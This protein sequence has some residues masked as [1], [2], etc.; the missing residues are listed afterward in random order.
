MKPVKFRMEAVLSSR[1]QTQLV[2]SY[3]FMIAVLTF[4]F[5]VSFYNLSRETIMDMAETDVY[6]MVR[7]NNEIID[8]K[9]SRVREMIVAFME[10]PDFHALY[11][12][13]DPGDRLDI[14]ISDLRITE[15]LSK[16]FSQSRDIYSVQL[17]ADFFTFGQN[18]TSNSEHGKN[19]I[20]RG[21]FQGSALHEA[22]YGGEGRI[23]WVPTYDVTE[24]FGIDVL[25]HVEIDYKYLWS[26]VRAIDISPGEAAPSPG[27][28]EKHPVLIVNFKEHLFTD[29]F[30]GSLPTKGSFYVV[31]DETG[32]VI[33][34][35][36]ASL[37]ARRVD[38]PELDRLT[39]AASGVAM[40][41]ID[42][43]KRIVSFDRSEIT[44]WYTIAVVPPNELLGPII[45]DFIRNMLITVGILTLFFIGLS[46]YFSN[47]ITQP[48]R[49]MIRAISMTGEGKFRI[50]FK[51]QGSYEFRVLMHRFNEMNDKIQRLIEENYI[52]KLREKEA[53]IKS[54][55]LQ[56]DPHFMH[57]T[58]NL[59]NL[60]ALEKGEDE[61]SELIT[62][63]SY[64]MKYIVKKDNLVTYEEDLTYLKSYVVIMTKRFEGKFT[65]EFDSDPLLLPTKVPKFFLQPIIENALIHGFEG[66]DRQGRISVSAWFDGNER[67]FVVR[68]N[69]KGMTAEQIGYLAGPGGGSV[70][71]SNVYRRIQ[72]IYGEHYGVSV[73]SVPGEGTTVTVRLPMDAAEEAAA[74]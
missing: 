34:H 37:L 36:D 25:R 54:L 4:L 74:G 52:I 53:E 59:I 9:L 12:D 24:M 61:I 44:G 35:P 39:A 18:I 56:L 57:N 41:E 28:K 17:A 51:E 43:K 3:I 72:A 2:V 49:A 27:M 26:A 22:A 62:G 63:L 64:M 8:S 19:F 40:M 50:K 69:G 14:M 29:V 20:P 46:S 15:I 5:G 47:I 1:L 70:G 48:I 23:V 33:S 71:L 11:A 38:W 67:V 13:I 55:N 68:D 30:A 42:G 60:I 16:Y 45:N 7:K 6:L 66:L 21:A 31:L 73:E 65:I 10:D 32:R 58:L